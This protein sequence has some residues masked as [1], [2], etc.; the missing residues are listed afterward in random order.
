MADETSLKEQFK[1]I[2]AE[3]KTDSQAARLRDTGQDYEKFLKERTERAMA[4]M[5]GKEKEGR[6]I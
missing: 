5:D 1:A 4:R 2:L 3:Q 6:E